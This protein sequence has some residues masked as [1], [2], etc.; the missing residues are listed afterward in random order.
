MWIAVGS[1][2]DR[3]ADLARGS[4]KDESRPHHP[5]VRVPRRPTESG[6]CR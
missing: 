2:Q 4:G 6:S 1:A 5:P 3:T